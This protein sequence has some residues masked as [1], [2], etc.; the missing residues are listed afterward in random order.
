[1]S[2]PLTPDIVEAA[3]ELLSATPPFKSWNLPAGEEIKFKV[4]KTPHLR[5]WHTNHGRK[6]EIAISEGCVGRI[7]TLLMT[8]A[9]E[10]IHLH[11]VVSGMKVSSE[12]DAAF[13]KLAKS[14]CKVHGW[15]VKAF[16]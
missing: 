13:M 7:D 4:A 5:G 2:L 16:R 10:M 15:D 11:Q 6:N 8:V 9:H 12:H 14:V 1:M 3:Y